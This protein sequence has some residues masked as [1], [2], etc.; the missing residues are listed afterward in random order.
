MTEPART[1]FELSE[2]MMSLIEEEFDG[3]LLAGRF[4]EVIKG[5]KSSEVE[6]IARDIFTRYGVDWMRKSLQ[7]G[8]EYTDRTYEVLRAAIDSTGG[9]LWF[10]L[11]P[12]R[13]LEIAYLSVQDMEFLPVIENNPRRLVYKIDACKVFQAIREACGEEVV[14]MLPCRHACLSACRTLFDDLD[15]PEVLISM[16]ASTSRDG[17]CQFAVTRE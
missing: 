16:D 17:Y 11:V 14:G 1:S 4:A 3:R 7:L 10:P 15:Y 6:S 12:Q 2:E 5:K 9:G 8:E 13:F